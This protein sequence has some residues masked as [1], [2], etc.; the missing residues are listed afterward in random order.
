M[1]SIVSDKLLDNSRCSKCDR[2]LSVMP[3]YILPN[4]KIV[5]GRCVD[6]DFGVPSNYNK[7]AER[8]LFKCVNRYEGCPKLLRTS[9]V[10][11]HEMEC[12]TNK[13]K[14]PVCADKWIPS[15]SM[16]PHFKEQH[17]KS[18]INKP[19]FKVS[20]LD[21]FKVLMY[22]TDKHIFF[23]D[24]SASVDNKISL[25][26]SCLGPSEIVSKLKYKFRLLNDEHIE[27]PFQN[28]YDDKLETNLTDGQRAVNC[29][30]IVNYDHEN[31]LSLVQ[32]EPLVPQ[33][34][35]LNAGTHSLNILSLN[36]GLSKLNPLHLNNIPQELL[37]KKKKIS[38]E[39]V[40]NKEN[41][42]QRTIFADET[43]FT[44]NKDWK[45]SPCKT[46]LLH[47]KNT[48]TTLSSICSS[49][50]FLIFET[51][52]YTCNCLEKHL[53]CSRCQLMKIVCPGHNPYLTFE[54]IYKNV[55]TQLKFFCKWNCGEYFVSSELFIHELSCSFRDPLICPICPEK[56]ISSIE[57]L[58]AHVSTH[59]NKSYVFILTSNI[60]NLANT[61]SDSSV[62]EK[63]FVYSTLNGH[64]L[65]FYLDDLKECVIIEL[66]FNDLN[67]TC[68]L[69]KSPQAKSRFNVIIKLNNKRVGNVFELKRN[70]NANILIVKE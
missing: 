43:F 55:H 56:N 69:K 34:S 68:T 10:V 21:T 31:S 67:C 6:V 63:F 28:F 15:Y 53:L 70:M 11:E 42:L 36:S 49:C 13:Y 7:I 59:K 14:C 20:R 19:E 35:H 40:G 9:E 47:K 27:T 25:S 2:Y 58:K 32:I 29:E 5:C 48:V 8:M 62:E 12:K 60:F 66:K 30:L 37:R 41:H 38:N 1:F 61:L 39:E 24:A 64:K 65:Y 44:G 51:V 17:N 57:C 46:L 3:V 4:Y 33:K 18:V 16:I 54:K 45:L 22:Y 23:I 50:K 26:T 52:M